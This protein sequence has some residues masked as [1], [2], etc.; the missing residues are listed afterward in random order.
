[1]KVKGSWAN[2]DANLPSEMDSRFPQ[3]DQTSG[4]ADQADG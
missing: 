3:Q 4:P 1:M 2:K